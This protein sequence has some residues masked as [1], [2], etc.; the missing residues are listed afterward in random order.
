M[1]NVRHISAEASVLL[2]QYGPKAGE[3][4]EHLDQTRIR[5]DRVLYLT[6]VSMTN[7]SGILVNNRANIERTVANLRDITDSGRMTIEKIRANPL[8]IS[9]LY[10]PGRDAELALANFDTANVVLKAASEFND[11]VKQ[12][13]A[14]R[15]QV[16]SPD[17]QRAVDAMLQRAAAINAQIDPLMRE[18]ARGV[19]AQPEPNRAAC[20]PPASDHPSWFRDFQEEG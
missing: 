9:P 4:I 10:K 5:A 8:L 3:L 2:Q 7:V 15:S 13:Q 1:A 18:L 17:Q 16:S 20:S 11:A 19:Q 14:V 6:D 12:L